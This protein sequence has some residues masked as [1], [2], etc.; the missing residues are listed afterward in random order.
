MKSMNLPFCQ[1][2]PRNVIWWINKF[3]VNSKQGRKNSVFILLSSFIDL[4]HFCNLFFSRK[5]K[6]IITILNQMMA[7][8]ICPPIYFVI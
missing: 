4:A 2:D 3:V 7:L 6:P 5:T 1:F 8:R